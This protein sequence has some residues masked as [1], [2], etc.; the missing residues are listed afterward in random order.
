M[1]LAM[2]AMMLLQPVFIVAGGAISN[3]FF[4]AIALLFHVDF[5][6]APSMHIE[7]CFA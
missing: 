5:N 2:L 4:S 1:L 7:A 6:A 3:A